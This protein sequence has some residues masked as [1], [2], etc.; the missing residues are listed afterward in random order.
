MAQIKIYGLL[1]NI[2]KHRASL[3][4][5]IH[6]SVVDALSYPAEKRFHRFIALEPDDF[7]LPSDRTNQYTIIEISMFEGRS[8]DARKALVR[9]LY[10]NIEAACGIEAND[11]EITITET[12]KENW[13]IRGMLG[14]E[15][16]LT[17]K[18]N[19]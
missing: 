12:P 4:Q 8:V 1:S 16:A 13:G 11:I 9:A 6:T 7:L 15:L 10:K 19:V 2:E 18:V 5:A 3:S 14:D 17:Y